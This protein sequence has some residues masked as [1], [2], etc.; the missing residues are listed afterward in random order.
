MLCFHLTII[1]HLHLE[2]NNRLS[3][4][5]CETTSENNSKHKSIM[6]LEL[7]YPCAIYKLSNSVDKLNCPFSHLQPKSSRGNMQRKWRKAQAQPGGARMKWCQVVYC[8][9]HMYPH[10]PTDLAQGSPAWKFR[11]GSQTF[12]IASSVAA[13]VPAST[14]P[15]STLPDILLLPLS[16][17]Q[18][19][20][21]QE[22]EQAL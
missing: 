3:I 12:L 6:Y 10:I 11:N 9:I 17:R 1:T 16:C 22:P 8:Y 5:N 18:P 2:I 21:N 19:S 20:V 13:L 15:P 4:N 14:Q 7:V